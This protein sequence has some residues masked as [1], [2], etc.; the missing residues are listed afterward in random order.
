MP[1]ACAEGETRDLVVDFDA[2][3]LTLPGCMTFIATTQT[4]PALDLRYVAPFVRC[5]GTEDTPRLVVMLSFR[6][7]GLSQVYLQFGDGRDFTSTL[8]VIT[9]I[10]RL[11]YIANHYNDTCL[12]MFYPLT[13][14]FNHYRTSMIEN[15]RTHS[16]K[17]QWC[18]IDCEALC[19]FDELDGC[20][21]HTELKFHAEKS[22]YVIDNF[23]CTSPSVTGANRTL[24]LH[25]GARVYQLC[26]VQADVSLSETSLFMLIQ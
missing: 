9:A 12:R 10:N 25:S 1:G 11:Q 23:H 6:G 8:N 2:E 15:G 5:W 16:E 21:P 18:T 14:A 22:W 26:P 3:T 17:I 7:F 13:N 4:F 20:E 19:M 24:Q